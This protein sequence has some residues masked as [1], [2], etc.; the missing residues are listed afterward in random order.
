[1]QFRVGDTF[2]GQMAEL[3]PTTKEVH[4]QFV[5]LENVKPEDTTGIKAAGSQPDEGEFLTELESSALEALV[6][7]VRK[8]VEELPQKIYAQATSRESD[9]DLDGAGA[10]P[11]CGS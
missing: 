2:S 1:L 3:V 5:L 6:M 10:S 9:S 11:F 8:R 4:K 7:A